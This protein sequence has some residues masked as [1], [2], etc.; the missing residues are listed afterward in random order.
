L[1]FSRKFY[2][3]LGSFYTTIFAEVHGHNLLRELLFFEKKLIKIPHQFQSDGHSEI[4]WNPLT[5]LWLWALNLH[6]LSG[7]IQQNVMLPRNAREIKSMRSM[8][9]QYVGRNRI[10][11]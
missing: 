11:F 5:P 10:I 2:E 1:K 4:T 3:F 8:P 9:S 7:S 6:S